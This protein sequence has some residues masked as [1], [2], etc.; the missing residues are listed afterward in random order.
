MGAY[1][2]LV[3]S[4]IHMENYNGLVRL[5]DRI[6]GDS[7]LLTDIGLFLQSMGL[8]K[9]SARALVK[10]GKVE[11]AI[12]VCVSM[13]EWKLAIDLAHEHNFENIDS[14][15]NQ[16]VDHLL[17]EQKYIEIV[18]VYRQGAF[19]KR[20]F[21]Q[22]NNILLFYI[23]RKANK[24]SNASAMVITL[25]GELKKSGKGDAALFKKLFVL[26]GMLHQEGRKKANK[27]AISNALDDLLTTD[28]AIPTDSDKK[29]VEDPWKG[30]F[31]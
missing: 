4:Y 30:K 5:I 10:A 16:Y 25:I 29:M 15:L 28:E 19:R 22:K 7:A 27:S 31:A 9:D 24:I 14:I 17:I 3:N 6:S 18:E 8:C 13:S 21:N 12:D 1:E 23:F 11:R 20:V 2:Q 26:I